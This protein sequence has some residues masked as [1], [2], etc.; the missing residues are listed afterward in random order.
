M[1]RYLRKAGESE[2][3]L[4][5]M[6]GRLGRKAARGMPSGLEGSVLVGWSLNQRDEE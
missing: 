4:V 3:C 1:G 2:Y 6:G 5:R